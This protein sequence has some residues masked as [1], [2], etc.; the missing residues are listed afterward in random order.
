M[1][2][3]MIGLKS[4]AMGHILG[5]YRTNGDGVEMLEL[6]RLA[7]DYGQD[8]PEIVDVIGVFPVGFKIR[9]SICGGIV[10][11]HDSRPRRYSARV[12]FE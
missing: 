1:A 8:M 6:F 12:A 4:C 11:W 2:K 7:I 5:K 3:K 9:C 10:D